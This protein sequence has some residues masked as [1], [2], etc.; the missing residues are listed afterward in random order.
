MPSWR[1]R[2]LPPNPGSVL[3]ASKSHYLK[4]GRNGLRKNSEPAV[5]VAVGAAVG[6][7]PDFSPGKRAFKPAGAL[8]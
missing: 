4:T 2:T 1:V 7:A 8:R 5:G 3:G 6:V